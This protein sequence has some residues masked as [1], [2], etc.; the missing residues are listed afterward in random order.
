MGWSF[1][2]CLTTY[3]WYMYSDIYTLC[4]FTNNVPLWWGSFSVSTPTNVNSPICPGGTRWGSVW[5][6]HNITSDD[7]FNHAVPWSMVQPLVS[8]QYPWGRQWGKHKTVVR[9]FYTIFECGNAQVWL[10]KKYTVT[11]KVNLNWVL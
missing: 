5:I 1:W 11:W 6:V 2:Q 9:L 7:P 3:R 8:N 4:L 10:S